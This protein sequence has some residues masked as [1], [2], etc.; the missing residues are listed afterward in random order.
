MSPQVSSLHRLAWLALRGRAASVAVGVE[1]SLVADGSFTPPLGMGAGMA[2]WRPASESTVVCVRVWA[3]PCGPWEL[4]GSMALNL[5]GGTLSRNPSSHQNTQQKPI[6]TR[7][8]LR[9]VIIL[10]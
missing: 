1:L 5:V 9:L 4:E 7:T 3:P 10:R 8:A 2:V 6:F